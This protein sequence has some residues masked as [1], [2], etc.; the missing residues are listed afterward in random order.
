MPA[1]GS[2]KIADVNKSLADEQDIQSWQ[3]SLRSACFDAIS[4]DD[5]RDI[6]T[7]QV[8]KA[9]E[10]DA[11]AIKFVMGH[12]LGG[13]QPVKIQQTNVITDVETAAR[14]AMESKQR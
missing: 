8:K 12:L 14:I 1:S 10:G 7:R 9:K 13:S 4:A 5:V 11:N 3:R 2:L 6:V